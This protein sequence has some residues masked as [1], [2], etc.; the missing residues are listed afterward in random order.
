MHSRSERIPILLCS[1]VCDEHRARA[2]SIYNDTRPEAGALKEISVRRGLPVTLWWSVTLELLRL[3]ALSA[4]V[5]VAV[6]AFAATI[7][8]L[9]D[10]KLEPM[11]AL[12][13]MAYATVPMLAY[14]LPFAACF[15]ATLTYHRLALDRELLAAMAAGVSHRTLLVPALAVGLTAG[16]GL[17]ALNEQIIPSF[18]RA[19]Q[20]LVTADI[21]LLLGNAVQRG[22]A[23]EMGGMWV[24]ADQVRQGRLPPGGEVTQRL[25][26]LRPCL[27]ET[28]PQGRV[29]VQGTA[30]VADLWLASQGRDASSVRATLQLQKVV[31]VRSDQS[32]YRADV[33]PISWAAP[34]AFQDDPKFLPWRELA[35]LRRHPE[36]MNWV[37]R[38]KG[39]LAAAL[40][41]RDALAGLAAQVRKGRD[42]VLTDSQER[43]L[44]ILGAALAPDSSPL[45][46]RLVPEP[47]YGRI[48]IRRA[49]AGSGPGQRDQLIMHARGVTIL[50][51]GSADASSSG[52]VRGMGGIDGI[53]GQSPDSSVPPS[54]CVLDLQL[55]EVLTQRPQGGETA[56][57]AG[58]ASARALSTTHEHLVLPG[59]FAPTPSPAPALLD[60]PS[61]ELARAGADLP[62]ARRLG[63]SIEDLMR[64]ITSKQHER[65]ALAV[66]CVVMVLSGALAASLLSQRLPL[67]VYLCAFLPALLCIIT[68]SGGQQMTHG[69]GS[70]GLLLLWGGVAALALASLGAYRVVARH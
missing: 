17:V 39:E 41:V 24:Y 70:A 22:Q 59:I 49:P 40:S 26:L 63:E 20:R 29:T 16:A 14:A 3:L 34:A 13:F 21:A 65:M 43:R 45:A 2:R 61:L 7:K 27:I 54:L 42:L 6:L 46:L 53:M 12:R 69:T 1:V 37:R 68:I 19:M 9:A 25:Q 30:E 52:G 5:L 32:V 31:G 18:L 36:G 15:A 62:Q 66:T 47:G 35:A 4:L 38:Q 28:D 10:G 55:S 60:V 11:Q 67:T 56:E 8:P 51:A 50:P 58:S 23:V 64:E 33:L 57:P 48:E 44:E